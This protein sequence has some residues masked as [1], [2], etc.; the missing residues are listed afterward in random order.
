V[1]DPAELTER[2][3]FDEL[4]ELLEA[5]EEAGV[6]LPPDLIP[7]AR[8]SVSTESDAAKTRD[9]WWQRWREAGQGAVE[10]A[11]RED[12]FENDLFRVTLAGLLEGLD[13]A[14]A[15]TRGGRGIVAARLQA[16]PQ[17]LRIAAQVA[18]ERQ[19]QPV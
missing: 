13:P 8:I 7:T 16:L 9:A 18:A 2:R 3:F 4:E 17:N 1:I 11:S 12:P 5:F 10:P 15:Y 6:E 19:P 14:I